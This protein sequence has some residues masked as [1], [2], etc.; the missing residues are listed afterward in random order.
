M[1]ELRRQADKLRL[2]REKYR[3]LVEGVQDYAIFMLDP[4][5][6]VASWNAGARRI[7]GYEA[8][9]IVGGHFSV[10][11][12]REAVERGWPEHELSVARRI[13]RFEDEG[14]RIRKD[15]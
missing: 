13:G 9:E 12:P 8:S 14:W 15:G 2:S 5:G 6:R 11:Y 1:T 4:D 3:M 7:K 10:F